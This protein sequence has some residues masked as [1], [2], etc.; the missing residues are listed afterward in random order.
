MKPT[1]TLAR[2]TTC[3][4]CFFTQLMGLAFGMEPKDL[5]IG[6]ELVSAKKRAGKHRCGS[7]RQ[8]EPKRRARRM[9]AC[10]CRV[11][12]PSKGNPNSQEE[13]K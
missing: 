4:S 2:T 8:Q 11:A 10:P 13:V 6:V 12:G 1:I 7:A 3:R 9:K 5:G